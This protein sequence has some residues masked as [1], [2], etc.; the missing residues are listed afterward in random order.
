MDQF[1]FRHGNLKGTPSEDVSWAQ[2]IVRTPGE[3]TVFLLCLKGNAIR[4][5]EMHS[6]KS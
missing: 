5:S 4:R 1:I 2:S 6:V 3:R